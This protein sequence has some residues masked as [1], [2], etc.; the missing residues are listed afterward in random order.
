MDE[1]G[2]FDEVDVKKNPEDWK[3]SIIVPLYKIKKK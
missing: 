1:A 2:I 3:K